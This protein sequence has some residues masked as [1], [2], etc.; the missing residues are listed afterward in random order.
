M[1]PAL[2]RHDAI[3]TRNILAH[4]AENAI[5]LIVAARMVLKPF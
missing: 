1:K 2:A 3:D 5:M 4:L